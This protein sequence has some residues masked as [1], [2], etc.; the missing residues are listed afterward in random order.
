MAIMLVPIIL[1]SFIRD[2]RTLAPLSMIANICCG[3]SLVVIIQYLI[4]NIQHTEKLPGFAGWSNFPVFFGIAMYA[5]EGIGVVCLKSLRSLSKPRRR[6]QRGSD[7]K[8]VLM[9]GTI[10]QHVYFKTLNIS[11]LFSTKQDREI[12]KTC[13]VWQRKT[14][15]QIF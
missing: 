9:G 1:L 3:I 5:F 10:A 13:V 2:L 4:R 7:K 8:K 14:R 6:Q 12:T 15:R 11:K